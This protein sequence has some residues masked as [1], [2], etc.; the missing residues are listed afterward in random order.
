MYTFFPFGFTKLLRGS[1]EGQEST[2]VHNAPLRCFTSF[3]KQST[4]VF[5]QFPISSFLKLALAIFGGKQ[6]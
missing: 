2:N 1:D 3:K 6:Q 5:Y 4:P